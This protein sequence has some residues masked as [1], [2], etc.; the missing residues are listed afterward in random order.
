MKYNTRVGEAISIEEILNHYNALF[1]SPGA[2]GKRT[3]SIMHEDA[4]GV[5]N[6]ID[7]FKG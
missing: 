5:L 4:E 2:H 1:I 6:G 7:F 3:L